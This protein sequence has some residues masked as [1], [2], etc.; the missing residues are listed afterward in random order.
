MTENIQAVY[1]GCFKD[2]NEIKVSPMSRAF[3]FSDSIYE[4]IPFQNR[5]LIWAKNYKVP[6]R[7]N[8]KIYENKTFVTHKY[9]HQ[10]HLIV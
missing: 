1:Q 5:K 2:L 10:C 8:L 7:S 4:V 9:S 3:L 6:F